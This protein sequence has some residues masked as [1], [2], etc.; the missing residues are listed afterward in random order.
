MGLCPVLV[1]C[2]LHLSTASDCNAIHEQAGKQHSTKPST[3]VSVTLNCMYILTK[4]QHSSKD[5][6]VKIEG[7][8]SF[9]CMVLQWI[10][11]VWMHYFVCSSINM[12]LCFSYSSLTS[13]LELSLISLLW[14]HCTLT[15][16]SSHPCQ[17]SSLT[18]YRHCE[19][20][21]R[22]FDSFFLCAGF[23]MIHFRR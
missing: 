6:L 5:R 14:T 21:N 15:T 3:V 18:A 22:K 1:F 2:C 7:W 23:W 10:E 11:C 9:H 4:Q 19:H 20:K 12:I 8:A 13:H 17:W 16:T